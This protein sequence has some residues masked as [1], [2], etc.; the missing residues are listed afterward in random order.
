M[1]RRPPS[2]ALPSLSPLDLPAYAYAYACWLQV[3]PA[4]LT[5]S[6]Q[7]NNRGIL[8]FA[9]QSHTGKHPKWIF[10]SKRSQTPTSERGFLPIIVASN[11]IAS[12]ALSFV[13]PHSPT[14]H[15]QSHLPTYPTYLPYN[16]FGKEDSFLPNKLHIEL[17]VPFY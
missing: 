12:P 4:F 6:P 5:T 13:F 16:N 15:I 17:S 7:K 10:G 2:L 9:I 11:T 14:Y 1:A 3:R 8:A